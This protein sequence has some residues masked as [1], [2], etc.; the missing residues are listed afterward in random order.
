MNYSL[1]A[2]NTWDYKEEWETVNDEQSCWLN[3]VFHKND[4]YQTPVVLNPM[5]TEGNIFIKRENDLAKDRLISL[6]FNGAEKKNRNFTKINDKNIVDSLII[7]LNSESVERKWEK[8]KKKWE[9]DK[10]EKETEDF[11]EYLKELI[12]KCW[13]EKYGFSKLKTGISTE[14]DS[15]ILYLIYKTISIARTY[16]ALLE[17]SECL[18]PFLSDPW[19]EKREQKLRK[20][21]NEI[22]KDVS[23]ITFKLRQTLAF[24]K[25][26][27]IRTKNNKLKIS[28]DEFA[29]LVDGKINEHWKYIDF[30]PA[31][32]FDTEIML[33][34]FDKKEATYP[35][36]KL[37]SGEK[38][39]IY[40]V[41]GILYHL[42]NINS[43][44]SNLRRV[45]YKHLNIVLDEIE[46]Y[47]HPEYQ[48]RFIDFMLKC[49]DSLRFKDVD[50]INIMMATHSPFIL[51]DIPE[52]NVL[53]LKE[54]ESQVGISET[55]G[56]NIHTLYRDTFF[57]EGMAIGE[58]AKNKISSL[59]DEV[60]VLRTVDDSL[61]NNI[62]LVGEPILRSQLL[63]LY[64]QNSQ[65]D[66]VERVRKLEEEIDSL[67]SKSNDKN[68]N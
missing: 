34:Q 28:I 31:P 1:H 32:I 10:G 5:R 20:L 11:F 45:K 21:I 12:L 3:G 40:T 60:R 63:K 53:Y 57:I 16:D 55:F 24:L 25:F 30:V 39:L 22:D 43:I 56:A 4:G 18:V 23:H 66:L 64:N 36:T 46:L 27:H 33:I 37:S 47:F 65:Y 29:K 19:D 50:S 2:F 41:S 68:R 61:Y 44:K 42:R 62:Q 6:F 8:L 15:A 49:I 51:S 38:Q 17:N 13:Q 54:G 26:K 7:T 67:K 48:R 35:F 58:F 59:F 52:S 9:D 14:Y